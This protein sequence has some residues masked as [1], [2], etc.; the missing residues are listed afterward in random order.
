MPNVPCDDIDHRGRWMCLRCLQPVS[1]EVRIG[2]AEIMA[3][4]KDL[5]NPRNL[6]R[7]AVIGEFSQNV[8][9]MVLDLVIRLRMS[10]TTWE[11]IAETLKMDRDDLIEIY[12]RPVRLEIERRRRSHIERIRNGS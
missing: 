5:G 1:A 11:A 9:M 3:A 6:D 4:P 2:E 7:L 10:R 12:G 8:Q